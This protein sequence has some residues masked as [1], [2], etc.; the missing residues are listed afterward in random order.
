MNENVTLSGVPETMLQTLYVRAKESRG[1]G[2]IH[3]AKAGEI[4]ARLDCD[5]THADKDF[6]SYLHHGKGQLVP[7]P[8]NNAITQ[9]HPQSGT[10]ITRSR[11]GAISFS[12]L[13][14]SK[15][16]FPNPSIGSGTRPSACRPCR[17]RREN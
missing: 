17:R 16:Y 10:C 2:A 3:D 6:Q 8:C 9:K 7:P 4:V 5:F 15:Y 11:P 12:Y 14:D 1:R 13:T